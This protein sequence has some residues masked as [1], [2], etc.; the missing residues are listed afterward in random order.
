MR[1]SGDDK[2]SWRLAVGKARS[3]LLLSGSSPPPRPHDPR[4]PLSV[5]RA[6]GFLSQSRAGS[7]PLLL[8]SLGVALA[9]PCL[10]VFPRHRI[11]SRQPLLSRFD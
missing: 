5:A 2:G 10:G 3:Q 11:L 4:S 9:L 6:S 8:L 7:G 1:A